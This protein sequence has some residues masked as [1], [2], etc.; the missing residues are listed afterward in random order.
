MKYYSI[1]KYPPEISYR[2]SNFLLS[3]IQQPKLYYSTSRILKQ[4][5]VPYEEGTNFAL[6]IERERALLDE[7]LKS[8]DFWEEQNLTPRKI[9]EELDRYIIGQAKAKRAVATALRNRYRRL[10]IPAELKDEVIPKNI[11]MVGPT[12]CGKTEISRRLAKLVDAPFIKVEATKFTEVGFH[13]KDVD[14][15]IRDLLE[16]S[17]SHVRTTMMKRFKAKV[18]PL[19]DQRLLELL[20]GSSVHDAQQWKQML[21][22]GLLESR[23]VDF[24]APD[25]KKS[26]QGSQIQLILPND[27]LHHLIDS[28]KKGQKK[29][30][31]IAECRPLVEQQELEKL[32][33]P[34]LINKKAIEA[35]E[36]KGIVVIDEIDK[37]CVPAGSFRDGADASDEGVQ[38]D[39]LPL[40]EGTVINTRL[41][42]VDTSKILFIASGAF[43]ACKPSDLLPELQGRLPIQVHLQGL[44]RNEFYRILTEPETNLIRQYKEMM[45]TENVDLQ[46][47][48]EAIEEIARIAAEL[49]ETTENIGAR[50]LHALIEAVVDDVSFHC[51]KY[52]NTTVTI[53]PTR[54]RECLQ[55]VLKK[56]DL[57]KFIL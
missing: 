37:I 30:M 6:N 14:Q 46:F 56:S 25:P 19:V 42:N 24:E 43:H 27:L 13:G 16:I 31:T 50:R 3:S 54:V 49:N 35:V 45:K 15:I 53:S 2:S 51:D 8:D 36:Q 7:E 40:I 26:M 1:P 41:G 10:K 47:E 57:S 34:E 44:T 48:K 38:R 32:I 5:V 20:T 33:S 23:A 29:K 22:Q 9:V 4:D 12:G 18:K 11:L 39:L 52:A 17:V 55:D 28:T 21:D